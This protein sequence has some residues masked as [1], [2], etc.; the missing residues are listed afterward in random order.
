[1]ITEKNLFDLGYKKRPSH[2]SGKVKN[3]DYII[4]NSGY[5]VNLTDDGI[6]S[7]SVGTPN[8]KDIKPIVNETDINKFI[9]W[10]NKYN[11]E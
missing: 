2:L 4:E 9:I 1:M 6:L 10:H 7:V 8:K 5:I 3:S 11:N